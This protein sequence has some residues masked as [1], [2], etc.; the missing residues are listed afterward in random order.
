MTRV[1]R[2]AVV[3][4]QYAAPGISIGPWDDPMAAATLDAGIPTL[5]FDFNRSSTRLGAYQ[6]Q[7][8]IRPKA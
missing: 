1:T 3:G 5:T 8:T 6:S 7:G 2:C 4:A